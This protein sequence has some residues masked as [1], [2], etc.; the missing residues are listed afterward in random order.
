[1]KKVVDA[2]YLY[3]KVSFMSQQKC[4]CDVPQT[5]S[6]GAN[7]IVCRCSSAAGNTYSLFHFDKKQKFNLFFFFKMPWHHVCFTI[8]KCTEYDVDV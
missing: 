2:L 6:V 3:N 1:M 8:I 7:E 5:G 4:V